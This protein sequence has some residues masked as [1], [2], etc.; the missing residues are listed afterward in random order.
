[1]VMPSRPVVGSLLITNSTSSLIIGLFRIS[2][3]FESISVVC[4]FLGIF[5]FHLSYLNQWPITVHSN[6][7]HSFFISVR[8]A[9]ITLLILLALAIFIFLADLAEDLLVFPKNQVLV[10]LVLFI[11]FLFSTSLIS[12]LF[13][14][15]SF[16]L[17]ALGLVWSFSQFFKVKV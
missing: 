11:I 2:I 16:L 6:L 7:L 5:P 9:V 15:I 10:P 17:L 3:F 14:I 13:F 4:V 8:L 12:A 1:M